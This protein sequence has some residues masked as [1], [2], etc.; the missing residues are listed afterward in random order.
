MP[1][2][3]RE[4]SE[5]EEVD[6]R[7]CLTVSECPVNAHKRKIEDEEVIRNIRP[8]L[9][10]SFHVTSNEYRQMIL[11]LWRQNKRLLERATTAEDKYNDLVQNVQNSAYNSRR[12]PVCSAIEFTPTLIK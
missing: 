7:T 2:R 12:V 5:E 10:G 11:A 8:R 1:K 6:K 9:N 4:Y 3:T